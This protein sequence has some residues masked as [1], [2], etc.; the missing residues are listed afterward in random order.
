MGRACLACLV[1]KRRKQDQSVNPCSPSRVRAVAVWRLATAALKSPPR[2]ALNEQTSRLAGVLEGRPQSA[3]QFDRACRYC[4][5]RPSTHP[6]ARWT[7]CWCPGLSA[8][9]SPAHHARAHS[10]MAPLS[11]SVTILRSSLISVWRRRGPG[12]ERPTLQWQGSP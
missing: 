10:P 8:L 9:A 7:P 2:H 4:I 12:C 11:T 5:A 3:R 1:R 6:L